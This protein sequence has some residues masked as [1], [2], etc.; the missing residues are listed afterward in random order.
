[1]NMYLYKISLKAKGVDR[2]YSFS[3]KKPI[4]LL[5]RNKIDAEKLANER[6]MDDLKVVSVTQL[7]KQLAPHIFSGA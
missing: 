7:A 4:Y 3:K 5:A 2:S 6:I 1:M